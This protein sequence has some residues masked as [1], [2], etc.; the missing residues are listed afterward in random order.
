MKHM[1][2]SIK[3]I[4]LINLKSIIIF[5]LL[6]KVTIYIGL[7]PVLL[8]GYQFAF[9]AMGH[10][11]INDKNFLKILAN[12]FTII[13]TL[14]FLVALLVLAFFEYAS[15]LS[16]FEYSYHYMK[17]SVAEMILLGIEKTKQMLKKN[18]VRNLFVCVTLFPITNIHFIV[19][20]V[21]QANFIS[22]SLG[23]LMKDERRVQII[24]MIIV[25]SFLL[26]ML[27][28]FVMPNMLV[29]AKQKKQSKIKEGILLIRGNLLRSS[30]FVIWYNVLIAVGMF[31][32]RVAAMLLLTIWL[33][34]TNADLAFLKMMHY[35]ERIN[36]VLAFLST[37]VGVVINIAGAFVLFIQIQ[38]KRTGENVVRNH[39][40]NQ[41]EYIGRAKK[42]FLSFL[43]AIFLV[44]EGLFVFNTAYNG[45]HLVQD[46]FL[47]SGI[48]AHRGDS[49][50]APENTMAAIEK[51]VEA[52]SDY[53]EIDIRLT[54]DGE[55]ILAH[56]NSFSRTANY[57]GQ[58]DKMTLE[59]IKKVDVGKMFS[60][61]F[62]G[63]VPPTLSEVLEYCKGKVYLN[64]E[65]KKVSRYE[66][67]I[68]KLYEQL[69][70]YNFTEQCV[71][72]STESNY[73]KK[74]KE[75]DEQLRTGII[76]HFVAGEYAPV[77][78]I[79]FVSLNYQFATEAFVSSVHEK[80]KEVHV[81]TVNSREDMKR[82]KNIGVDNMITDVPVAAREVVYKESNKLGLFEFLK[83]YKK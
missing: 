33:K 64:I 37:I 51:A 78:Y 40:R 69:E 2:K 63:E 24:E 41:K 72:T 71:I 74:L 34:V 17:I 27:A 8:K 62:E 20:I 50:R 35:S 3:R 52:F 7:W 65:I 12:P 61:E 79:D 44:G 60:K 21:N 13:M 55:I 19:S 57:N 38:E 68:E 67:L 6:L 53:V 59:E 73:L 10:S 32:L 81:W 80:G 29:E 48:T 9:K 5:E 11:F 76:L 30:L 14:V 36:L 28:I 83:R 1:W 82:M 54:A 26:A 58:V 77:D 25:I 22:S 75:Y 18:I 16:C 46:I 23:M 70:E 56:D 31:L 4:L 15:L 42:R 43:I 47:Y 49:S 45:S 39:F 66:E